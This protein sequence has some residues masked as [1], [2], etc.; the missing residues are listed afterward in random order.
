MDTM[1]VTAAPAMSAVPIA[2]EH[3]EMLGE[4][5]VRARK[6]LRAAKM[7]AFNGW[8]I[9]AFAALS[10]PFAF[11][12][13]DALVMCLGLGAVAWNEFRG[14][15]MMLAFDLRA[16]RRLAWGQVGLMALLV[17]YAAWR[18]IDSLTGPGYYHEAAGNDP[19]LQSK[20]RPYEELY[21]TLTVAAYGALICFTLL[22]QGLNALYYWTR[23][24]PL[25]RYLQT[26][27]RWIVQLQRKTNLG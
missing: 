16:P 14:R 23:R 27:P 26:T 5:N 19:F 1:S 4:A 8:T 7:A 22:F 20:L 10:L 18:I 25:I 12:G 17:C 15:R 24:R 11:F 2:P 6:V 13:I 21:R 3:M 9:G